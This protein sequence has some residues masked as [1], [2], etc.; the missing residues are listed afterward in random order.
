MCAATLEKTGFVLRNVWPKVKQC[1]N[2]QSSNFTHCANESSSS[3]VRKNSNK[4]ETAAANAAA[5][6][7]SRPSAGGPNALVLAQRKP[8]SRLRLSERIPASTRHLASAIASSTPVPRPT[9]VHRIAD[10]TLRDTSFG[11]AGISI[12]EL[13]QTASEKYALNKDFWGKYTDIP[14]MAMASEKEDIL[15]IIENF[16]L[17]HRKHVHLFRHLKNTVLRNLDLWSAP[18]FAA[19]C[20]AWA[21][22]GFLHED[23]CIAMAERV[24]ATAHACSTQEIV[25]LFD[26]YAT[27]RCSVQSVTDEI[28]RQ[29]LLRMDDFTLPQLCLHAS[30]FAR[31][32]VSSPGIFKGIA[33]RLTE[34]PLGPETE[35]LLSARDITLAAYA[36]A[37]LGFHTPEVFGN[38]AWR[39]LE[40]IR[41]FTA[42]DLQMF[43][44][45]L[46]RA[47]Y[48]DPELLDGISA[49]AQ[50]RIAQFS[51]ESLAL[52]LHTMALFGMGRDP[53]FT[54]AVIQLTRS[55]AT[56]RPTDVALL[57][58]AF[59]DAQFHSR[60]LFDVVTP[61][62]LE[63]APMFTPTDWLSALHAYSSLGWK[64][65][66]FLSAF[67]LHL[68]ASKLSSLQLCRALVDCSRLSHAGASSLLAEAAMA[69]GATDSV[70]YSVDAA[71]QMYSALLLLGHSLEDTADEEVL[72]FL[73]QLAARL[74]DADVPGE[75]SFTACAN[76]CYAI[77][78]APPACAG[79]SAG[80]VG[81]HPVD[82]LVLAE[83]CIGSMRA[84][85]PLSAEGLLLLPQIRRALRM[86]P[87]NRRALAS[88]ERLEAWD[89]CTV[90]SAPP[91]LE[92]VGWDDGSLPP[93]FC[94]AASSHLAPHL[95][96]AAKCE[97][98]PAGLASLASRAAGVAPPVTFSQAAEGGA[99][100]SA[101]C[102][103][104]VSS[105][106]LNRGHGAFATGGSQGVFVA[107]EICDGLRDVSAALSACDVEHRLVLDLEAETHILIR[108]A[109][110]ARLLQQP[111]AEQ[112][113]AHVAVV[114]GSTVH[115]VS[116]AA[117]R[118]EPRL[119]PA[120]QFQLSHLKAAR[121]PNAVV[122]PFWWWPPPGSLEERG[123]ALARKLW[124]ETD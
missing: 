74:G 10:T 70:A 115:Y 43:I 99:C 40:V 124:H 11:K 55:I 66:T 80:S 94:L 107:H 91:G 47:Q 12:D 16:V 117:A 39:A 69:R 20:H 49:Q 18:D 119:T 116:T 59:A 98:L 93:P 25:W 58:N 29:T 68:D 23:L 30:S 9:P 24:N 33:Q 45:A 32:N 88:A 56:F 86:L 57:L 26:A 51:S 13:V 14:S 82:A 60:A 79:G 118:H 101:S 1:A 92:A 104:G 41:D 15:Q 110:L 38:L 114:W 120:A 97:L 76:L 44:V 102:S 78:V 48:A 42:R 87:W 96:T 113:K 108:R 46:A 31:L 109:A 34:A 17:I 85:P 27:A 37:K 77:M 73:E 22:L 53:L 28:N 71:A 72:R 52:T 106:E 103:S 123:T 63:K 75:L 54:R 112:S 111:A 8:Q 36:F 5:R 19:L 62:I 2:E 90:R 83:R 61:F 89:S 21:Q 84:Q 6:R 100:S 4:A 105:S 121:T 50:R 67:G 7:C 65:V 95:D 35:E 64:D 3:F 81:R 122:V